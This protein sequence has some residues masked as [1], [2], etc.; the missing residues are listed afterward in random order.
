[1]EQ[2]RLHHDAVTS[3]NRRSGG[4]RPP[5]NRGR[6]QPYQ[7]RPPFNAPR[8]QGRGFNRSQGRPP[9][10]N[11]NYGRSNGGRGNFN[12]TPPGT[13]SPPR[14]YA[15]PH[16]RSCGPAR[17]PQRSNSNRETR[18][19]HA[20]HGRRAP[21]SNAFF[22]GEHLDVTDNNQDTFYG[23]AYDPGPDQDNFYSS[24]HS[25]P[26]TNPYATEQQANFY[27]QDQ[28]GASDA[29]FAHDSSV[30]HY[31]HISNDSYAHDS[32]VQHYPQDPAYASYG[33]YDQ[34]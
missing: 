22:Q 5:Q 32:S 18:N 6:F 28:N 25:Q 33:A 23:E 13:P 9:Y 16:T 21:H 30:Q 4:Q 29:F 2:Q 7:P 27:C 8:P 26:A 11:N 20:F 15:Q 19:L 1:M 12:R 3:M 14:P 10:R 24:D 31:D 34:Y 17:T